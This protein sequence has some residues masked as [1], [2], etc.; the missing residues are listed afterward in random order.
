MTATSITPSH[1]GHWGGDM[2]SDLRTYQ[3]FLRWFEQRD[4]R[5]K[6]RDAF[7]RASR[8]APFRRTGPA[9][10]WHPDSYAQPGEV[11]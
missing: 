9:P 6:A 11:E 4:R 1:R 2:P 5:S 8:Y 3:D 10:Q 7:L